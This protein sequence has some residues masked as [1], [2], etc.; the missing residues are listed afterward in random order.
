MGS[1]QA[2][3][4]AEGDHRR[5]NI[6]L[7][8]LGFVACAGAAVFVLRAEPAEAEGVDE[9]DYEPMPV[10]EAN[11]VHREFLAHQLPSGVSLGGAV[12]VYL[13]ER[14]FETPGFEVSNWR[15]RSRGGDD[16]RFDIGWEGEAE[17]T[18][19]R[20]P[21][22][23]LFERSEGAVT[24]ESKAGEAVLERATRLEKKDL[25][26]VLPKSYVP[27]PDE[28]VSH[29]TGRA[30]KVCRS[31]NFSDNCRTMEAF[32]QKERVIEDLGWMMEVVFEREEA[33]GDLRNA[34]ACRWR[35]ISR[36]PNAE[37]EWASHRVLYLC[38]GALMPWNFRRETGK[39][40]ALTD[41]THLL[42][43]VHTVEPDASAPPA[44]DARIDLE[45]LRETL[46]AVD[47][48]AAE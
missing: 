44:A 4:D 31:A 14:S 32:F 1:T 5:R 25:P 27:D 15:M 22:A 46:Q 43:K 35:I 28:G 16:Y 36:L 37:Q 13:T 39:F 21:V 20:R 29:W 40:S 8:I 17:E 33:F 38:G 12:V 24:A 18:A 48:A 3:A 23:F 47:P 19:G 26:N 42:A 7:V 9:P 30:R 11:D 10:G 2:S 41:A 6:L 45:E 34:G